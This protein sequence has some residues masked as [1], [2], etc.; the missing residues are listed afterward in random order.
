VLSIRYENGTTDIINDNAATPAASTQPITLATAKQFT[1]SPRLNTIGVTFGYQGVS[2]FGFTVN[3]TVS[4]GDYTFFDFN[5]GLGFESFAFN[6]RINFNAF[7]PFN[8]GGWYAGIGIGGG[9]NE[10]FEKK[11]VIAGNITTGF[12]FFNW[13]NI[14]YTLQVGNFDGYLNHNAIVGYAYRFKEQPVVEYESSAEN[15]QMRG[16]KLVNYRGNAKNVTIPAGVTVIGDEA[17]ERRTSL[18]SVTIPASVTSIENHAFRYCANLETVAFAEGSQL[19]SIGWGVFE[20]C[21]SLT[22]ITIPARV[23]SI[24]YGGTFRGCTNLTSITVDTNNPNFASEGGILYNKT[25][26]SIV[27]VPLGITGNVTISDTATSIND[28]VFKDCIKLTSITFADG[29]Q[30]QTI[31][32]ESFFGCTGLKTVTF[33]DS[34]QLASIGEDA[35]KGCTNLTSI[36]IPAS[37]TSIGSW[38]FYGCDLTSVTFEGSA[39]IRRNFGNTAFPQG[40]D[41]TGNSISGNALRTAYLAGGAGTYTR[42]SGGSVWTKQP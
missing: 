27:I 17:F 24:S 31:G 23:T 38:A 7:V 19:E 25:K 36:T 18:V 5:L 4:P 8:N 11:G 28:S 33:A 15:F 30:L 40:R 10:S 6:A 39:V 14:G 35:F 12:I 2:A 9:Y 3:G 34:S 13:L 1:P 42:A 22:R 41:I 26:T 32:R 37:V 29:S 20:G 21:T 16:T